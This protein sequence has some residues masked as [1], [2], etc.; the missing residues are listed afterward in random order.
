[1]KWTDIVL[2]PETMAFGLEKGDVLNVGKREKS[3]LMVV[4]LYRKST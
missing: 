2:G 3:A 1:M 4:N